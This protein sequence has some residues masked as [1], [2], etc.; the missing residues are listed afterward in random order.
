L[1]ELLE[2]AKGGCITDIRDSVANMKESDPN[3][4]PFANRIAQLTDNFQ[5]DQIIENIRM[6]MEVR[7]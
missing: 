2:F 4:I 7:E 3:L 5:F 6:Y 1:K